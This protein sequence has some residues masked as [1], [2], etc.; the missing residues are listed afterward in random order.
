MAGPSSC[1]EVPGPGGEAKRRRIR[2]EEG[3]L[4]F[5]PRVLQVHNPRRRKQ[6][7]GKFWPAIQCK[8]LSLSDSGANPVNAM[9]Q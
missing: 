2:G 9:A 8:V 6:S 4:K 5:F 1:Q 3:S 7:K